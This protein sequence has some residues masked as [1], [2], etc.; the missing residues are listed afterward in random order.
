MTLV[1]TFRSIQ[2]RIKSAICKIV[3]VLHDHVTVAVNAEVRRVQHFGVAL[4]S[5]DARDEGLAILEG[6][7]PVPWLYRQVI[8]EHDEDRQTRKRRDLL[9]RV[10]R[11]ATAWRLHDDHPSN[12]GCIDQWLLP[13]ERGRISE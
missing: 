4:G 9:I 13:M 12:S 8:A 11:A 10:F 3:L 7:P 1:P 5:V 6:S 2:S